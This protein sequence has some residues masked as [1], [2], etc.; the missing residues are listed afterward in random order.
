MNFT[1]LKHVNQLLEDTAISSADQTASEMGRSLDDFGRS[2]AGFANILIPNDN[3]GAKNSTNPDNIKAALEKG[4]SKDQL[5][6]V[7]E[8][9]KGSSNMLYQARLN[10]NKSGIIDPADS[11]H[12]CAALAKDIEKT[13]EQVINENNIDAATVLDIINLRLMHLLTDRKVSI[14]GAK[15]LISD[16]AKR[17]PDRGFTDANIK[18]AF[19]AAMNG[20]LSA[21]IAETKDG[22][23]SI[24]VSNSISRILQKHYNAHLQKIYPYAA[25]DINDFS[26]MALWNEHLKTAY[27]SKEVAFS[28]I[29][30]AKIYKFEPEP[31]I[32]VW[33]SNAFSGIKSPG[34]AENII[35][36]CATMRGLTS[37]IVTLPLFNGV[38]NS[39]SLTKGLREYKPKMVKDT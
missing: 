37:Y 36:G 7:L 29:A 31:N 13:I 1:L 30:N 5:Q 20:V 10:P 12:M 27:A 35:F 17:P 23:S 9:F 14:D 6:I 15:K 19:I 39:L 16:I 28:G 21:I 26:N 32:N 11:S 24:G 18:N 33:H 8:S 22:T 38:K 25:G 2:V 34:V 4:L 3:R